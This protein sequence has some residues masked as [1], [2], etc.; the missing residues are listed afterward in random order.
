MADVVVTVKFDIDCSNRCKE[1]YDLKK[2]KL[3]LP[4]P[5]V[6]QKLLCKHF[7]DNT[8]TCNIGCKTED[9][10]EIAPKALCPYSKCDTEKCACYEAGTVK[11]TCMDGGGGSGAWSGHECGWRIHGRTKCQIGC[12]TGRVGGIIKPLDL[13]PYGQCDANRC[14]CFLVGAISPYCQ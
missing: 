12:D 2:N 7:D 5:K 3:P 9:K 6:P 4:P 1:E 8:R 14:P 10:G 11:I 13:C